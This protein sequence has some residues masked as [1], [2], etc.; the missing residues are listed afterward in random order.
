MWDRHR[1]GRSL[2]KQC[3]AAYSTI[4]P[5]SDPK[6]SVCIGVGISVEED[7]VCHLCN[8]LG[9]N[10]VS[11]LAQ[12]NHIAFCKLIDRDP[13]Q[14][15]QHTLQSSSTALLVTVFNVILLHPSVWSSLRL[16]KPVSSRYMSSVI[17]GQWE[18]CRV[19]SLSSLDDCENKTSLKEMQTA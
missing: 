8:S 9:I 2:G 12:I 15:R 16:T 5:E 6:I 13:T 1:Y 17:H 4:V 7:T 11:S 3:P 10:C 14:A 18:S 19:V